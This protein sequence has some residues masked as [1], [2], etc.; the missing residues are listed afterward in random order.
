MAYLYC[1]VAAGH[2]THQPTTMTHHYYH[3]NDDDDDDDDKASGA[4]TAGICR[5]AAGPQ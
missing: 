3:Y 2:V 4:E 5:S 1:G